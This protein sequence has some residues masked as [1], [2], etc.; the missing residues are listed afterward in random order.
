M[1]ENKNK[2]T[3]SILTNPDAPKKEMSIDLFY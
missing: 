1:N 2:K 3:E